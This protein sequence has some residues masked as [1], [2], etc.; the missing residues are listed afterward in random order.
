MIKKER[1]RTVQQHRFCRFRF[2]KSI[3]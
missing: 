1:K 2:Y 3:L